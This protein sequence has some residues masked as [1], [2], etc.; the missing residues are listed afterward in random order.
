MTKNKN[1]NT[2]KPRG[3]Y[4]QKLQVSASFLDVIKVIVK[5]PKDNSKKATS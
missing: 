5:D 2:P 3:K 1:T 4:D